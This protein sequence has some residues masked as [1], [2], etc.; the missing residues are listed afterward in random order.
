MADSDKNGLILFKNYL[1][2]KATKGSFPP[3]YSIKAA[4]LDNNFRRLT[5]IEQPDSAYSFY[6][7]EVTENGTI[8]KFN[9]QELQFNGRTLLIVGK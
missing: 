8:L 7:V 6:A 3:P 2:Q 9:T 1:G 5:I 4:D